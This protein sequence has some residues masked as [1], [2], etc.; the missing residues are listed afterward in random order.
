VTY[1]FKLPYITLTPTFSICPIH[2]Y[3]SGEHT[4]CPQ[5]HTKEELEMHGIEIEK[6]VIQ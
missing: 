1:N 6:E 2:G 4:T 3:V 5:E